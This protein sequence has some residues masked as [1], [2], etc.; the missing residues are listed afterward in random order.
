M[1]RKI[2]VVCVGYDAHRVYPLR[3]GTTLAK[4]RFGVRVSLEVHER[5]ALAGVTPEEA[6]ALAEGRDAVLV[7]ALTDDRMAAAARAMAEAT[8]IFLPSAPNTLEI[9]ALARLGGYRLED[10]AAQGDLARAAAALA[11]AGRPVPP[12]PGV[13]AQVLPQVAHLLPGELDGLRRLGKILQAL[14]NL[15]PGNAAIAFAAIAHE[16]DAGQVGDPGWPEVYPACGFWHPLTGIHATWEQ[17]ES[18]LGAARPRRGWAG[19]ALLVTFSTQITSG[20]DAHLRALV[21]AL[22]DAGI[23]V[24]PWFGALDAAGR[25]DEVQKIPGLDVVINASGFTLTGTHG[26][27]NV[28]G[29][30]ALLSAWGTPQVNAVPLLF[31]GIGAWQQDRLG[32]APVAVAMQVAIPELEA[33]LAPRV[34]AGRSE[35]DDR[36]VP[37]DLQVRRI[38]AHV[39]RIV[40][41]RRVPNSEKRVAIVLFCVPPDAGSVGTAAYLDV[42]A[43]LHALLEALQAAGYTVEVPERAEALLDMMLTDGGGGARSDVAMAAWYP[44]G[45][46]SR[47]APVLE[48]VVADWGPP[49][50]DVDTDGANLAIRGLLLGNVAI[51]VQPDNGGYSDPIGLLYSESASPSHSFVALYDWIRNRFRADAVLHFGTH[52]ALEFMPGK[53]AGL[54][55]DDF[56]EALIGGVPHLYYYCMNNPAEAAIARRRS[57][58]EIV[59]YLSPPVAEAGLYGALEEARDALA[60]VREEGGSTERLGALREAAEAAGLASIVP[61]ELADSAPGEYIERLSRALDELERTLIPLGLH[62]LGKGIGADEATGI[63]AAACRYPIPG[64]AQA[65]LFDELLTL[66]GDERATRAA[67]VALAEGVTRGAGDAASLHPLLARLPAETLEAW[68]RFLAERLGLLD[69]GR[70]LDGLVAALDGRYIPPAPGGDPVRE[71]DALPSG[72]GLVA[73]DPYRVP[74]PSAVRAGERLAEA[75]VVASRAPEGSS[76]KRLP[77]C[78]GGSKPSRQ[79]ARRSHRSCD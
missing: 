20:N 24:I 64:T 17:F 34:Y 41:L 22:E 4:E 45:E 27:P 32:L 67:I 8:G 49:P 48:P 77:W 50:G 38:A 65:P 51:V 53:Q 37:L 75:L 25:V 28:T 72:R 33:A 9:A 79:G 13:F 46:Y 68:R 26:Q 10:P 71:P 52:G 1:G 35:A 78:C 36:M 2:R 29:D 56:P 12:F 76:R 14:L 74:T 40:R 18:A 54:L 47:T 70:E 23:E 15:S 57:G 19:R 30:V 3:Q 58:A 21:E 61:A 5:D 6:R 63:L 7:A 11:A 39:A 60:R 66:S 43:S 31:Q 62:V 44:A 16:L 69:A 59:S 73:V 55:P 42:F